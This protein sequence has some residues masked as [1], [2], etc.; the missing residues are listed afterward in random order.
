MD[1][2]SASV[3]IEGH[4]YCSDYSLRFGYRVR[5]GTGGMSGTVISVV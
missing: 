5:C 1:L 2:V 3:R 4:G